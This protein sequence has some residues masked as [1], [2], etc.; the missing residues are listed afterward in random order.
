MTTTIHGNLQQAQLGGIPGTYHLVRSFLNIR[1]SSATP[2][3]EV[4]P[5]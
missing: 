4:S 3:L 5:I 1:L 2:G